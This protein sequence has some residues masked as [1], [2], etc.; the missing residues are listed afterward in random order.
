[1]ML[2]KFV[3]VVG[4][5]SLL[6]AAP[7]RAAYAADMPLKA[8]PSSPVA[9]W[10]G[11]Y[12]GGNVGGDWARSQDTWTNIIEAPTGFATG[13]ATVLPAAA[14]ATLTGSGP[15]GGGQLGC[16]YQAGTFVFG[17]EG[18]IDATN[19]S[20]T[21]TAT[22]VGTAIIVPGNITESFSSSWLSTIRGRLGVTSGNW[23]FYGTGG[24]AFANIGVADQVCFPTAGVPAC[25][26]GSDNTTRVGWAAGGGVELKLDAHW[27]AK[28]EYLHAGLGQFTYT[29][30]PS[31]AADPLATITIPRT[32]SEDM[33]RFGLN[34]Q[35]NTGWAH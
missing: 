25:V 35:F 10:T 9:T 11:C 5:S 34:F 33:V 14:N 23:L 2:H 15:I 8:P 20:T 13:A 31:I 6:I 24:V 17:L 32:L 27:T 21:R 12:V 16:N 3:G 4:V 30:F 22:S 26:S 29:A 18:D 19:L 7:L 28:V 1:M